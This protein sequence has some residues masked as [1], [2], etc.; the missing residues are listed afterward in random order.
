MGF[1]Y[2]K[3]SLANSADLARWESIELLVDSGALFTS[4]PRGI[5]ERLGIRPIMRR[6][7][8]V[9]GGGIVE[10]DLGNAIIEYKDSR[11]GATIIFGEPEDAPI[12]GA[13]SLESLGYQLDPVTGELKPIE[14]LMLH[15][16]K[17]EPIKVVVH[18]ALGR[19]GREVLN[20]L[21]QDPGL[22]PVGAVERE[23][24]KD[25]L[26]LPDGSKSIPFSAN[27][28]LIL[29]QCQPQVLVDFTIAEATRKAVPIAVKHKI[30]LVI[31]TTGLL[32]DDLAQIDKLT[33]ERELGA[34]VAPNF[35]LGA[36]VMVHLAKVA[37]RFFDYA[38]IIELHHEGKADAP[39]GTALSTVRAMLD[40]R[41]KPFIHPLTQKETLP[42]TRGGELGGVAL[43]S[44]RLPGL[45]A[46]Q[47]VIFGAQGQT[48]SL[49]HDATSRECYI[50]GILLAIKKVIGLKG[51]TYGLDALLGL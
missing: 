43:H 5:L 26:P 2:I 20:A 30:N 11:A 12:L 22:E 17:M 16:S 31:G 34:I 25:S 18:G 47:E 40:S 28:G 27:L 8:R 1:T 42:G 10:R 3:V 36:V 13:T 39:S 6:K 37:A 23:V 7:L 29:E 14:L 4:I 33:L 46:H 49:R 51:L 9:Y 44:V 35:A 48:L 21:C 32:P 50:P 41:D 45:V 15:I 19:M 24:S 38:E